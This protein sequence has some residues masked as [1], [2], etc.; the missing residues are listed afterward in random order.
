MWPWEHVALGYLCYSLYRNA[1]FG[2][3]PG[4]RAAIV[5]VV[6]SVLPDL[7]DKPLSWGV[8]WFPTGYSIAHS[9]FTLA[10]IAVVVLALRRRGTGRLAVAF[11]VGYGSHLLGDVVYP[12]LSG[13]GLA[14]R[15]VLWPL[16]SLPPYGE[17]LGPFSRTFLY[18][19]RYVEAGLDGD[20]S[21]AVAAGLA[22]V[23]VVLCLWIYDGAPGTWIGRSADAPPEHP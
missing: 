6:A 4:D 3:A 21:T 16:V 8:E 13:E 18:L 2:S 12:L 23:L 20:G 22:L 10:A 5:V 15:R 11:L 9:A 7:V 17:R 14:F 1:L 19:R